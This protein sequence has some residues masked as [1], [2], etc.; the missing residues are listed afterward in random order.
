M[1]PLLFR[2]IPHQPQ[3]TPPTEFQ[4]TQHGVW[5]MAFGHGEHSLGEV[6]YQASVGGGGD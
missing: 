2:A 4:F 5:L 6:T 3:G 1:R